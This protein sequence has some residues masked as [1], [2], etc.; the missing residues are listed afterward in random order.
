[1]KK[2]TQ[3]IK[4]PV[5]AASGM[6]TKCIGRALNAS[7]KPVRK[8]WYFDPSDLA[9]ALSK[10]G[11]LKTRWEALTAA[12]KTLWDEEP[13]YAAERTSGQQKTK[14]KASGAMTVSDGFD[15]YEATLRQ[16]YEGGQ[17]KKEHFDSQH[18]RLQALRN[19]TITFRGTQRTFGTCPLPAISRQ[20]LEAAVLVLCNRPMITS[21]H[22]KDAANKNG[23]K[24]PMKKMSVVYAKACK[25]TLKTCFAWMVEE[26]L[27]TMCKHWSAIWKHDVVITDDELEDQIEAEDGEVDHFDRDE[28]LK[29]WNATEQTLKPAFWKTIILLSLNCGFANAECGTLRGREVKQVAD[30]RLAGEYVI[31]RYRLKTIKKAKAKSWARWYLWPETVAYLKLTSQFSGREYQFIR[32]S[33]SRSSSGFPEADRSE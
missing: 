21:H 9:A 16:Q 7:G 17:V 12:G 3:A 13:Q 1:M 25:A 33:I 15:R 19:L 20:E 30:G 10:I 11:E 32:P 28:L 6:Y 5:H 22:Y 2:K 26:T 23:G 27:W 31:E 18:F 14:Q 24:S 4:L 29:L 8:D